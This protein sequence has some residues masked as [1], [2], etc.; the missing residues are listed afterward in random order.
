VKSEW[1]QDSTA[2]TPAPGLRV[3]QSPNQDFIVKHLP[4]RSLSF[5]DLVEILNTVLSVPEEQLTFDQATNI[6]DWY[7]SM[8]DKLNSINKS[9]TRTL[10]KLAHSSKEITRK[11][12]FRVKKGQDNAPPCL[13]SWLVARGFQQKEGKDFLDT[14]A[15][16]VKWST[17]RSVSAKAGACGWPISHLDV[18]IAC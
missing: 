18:K 2:S 5:R 6:P 16:V 9:Q 7:D 3:Y 8:L 11:W 10:V 12:V 13:K 15:P 4:A 17:V 14:F 1:F